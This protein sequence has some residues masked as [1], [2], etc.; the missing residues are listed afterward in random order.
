MKSSIRPALFQRVSALAVIL[1]LN[2][3][4]ALAKESALNYLET[5]KP[6]AATL[7]APPPLPGSTEQR[8][9]METVR[10]VC[11]AACS[12]DISAALSEKKFSLASFGPAIGPLFQPGKLPKMDAFFARVH[13]DAET[14][15]DGAKEHWQRP[16]PYTLDPSLVSGK[17]EKSFSYPSGH[18]TEAMVIALLLSEIFPERSD[19]ILAVGRDIGWHRVLIGRHYPTDIYSGRVLAQAVVKEMK[20]NKTF[21][22]DFAEVKAEVAAARN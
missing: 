13:K 18:S 12:N 21:Q 15:V 16:R 17:L 1:A 6:D 20:K 19:A 7:L 4:A 8:A 2:C 10:S 9:D 3:A 11:H 14:V 22:T 5:G